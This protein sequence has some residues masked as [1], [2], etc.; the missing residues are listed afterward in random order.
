MWSSAKVPNWAD[1][2]PTQT[3]G[4]KHFYGIRLTIS[5]A[6]AGGSGYVGIT[7]LKLMESRPAGKPSAGVGAY[8]A[9]GGTLYGDLVMASKYD[10]MNIR[11]QITNTGYI[12]NATYK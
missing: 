6:T 10:N 8:D 3:N 12:G 7:E 5:G 9:M 1:Y 11:P 4:Y 2:V